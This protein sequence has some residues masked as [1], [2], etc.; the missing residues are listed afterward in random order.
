MLLNEQEIKNVEKDNFFD[1]HI[2]SD[3]HFRYAVENALIPSIYNT[4]NNIMKMNRYNIKT[5]LKEAL[6]ELSKE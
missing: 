4:G 3:A 2:L 5:S 6:T 1:N